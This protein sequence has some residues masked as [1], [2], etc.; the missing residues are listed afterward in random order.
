MLNK[1]TLHGY[2]GKDPE[3]QE[4]ESQ[5]GP[6]LRANFSLA[7]SR[8]YGDETDWF[9]CV[10]YGKRAEVINRFFHKGSEILVE[11]RMESYRPNTEEAQTS[12]TVRVNDFNFCGKSSGSGNA[13]EEAPEGF[14]PVDENFDLF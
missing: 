5:K 2:M 3:L 11:G 14:V 6:F 9:Y 13:Q 12:W 8:D 10:V 7:V 4:F 1:I